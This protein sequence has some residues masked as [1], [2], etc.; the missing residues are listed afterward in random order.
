LLFA[1]SARSAQSSKS[2]G[3]LRHHCASVRD[4]ASAMQPAIAATASADR[5]DAITDESLQIRRDMD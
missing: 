5:R 4:D 3:A 2:F 1:F